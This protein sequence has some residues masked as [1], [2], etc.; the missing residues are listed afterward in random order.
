MAALDRLMSITRQWPAGGEDGNGSKPG[1]CRGRRLS[2][3][4]RMIGRRSALSIIGT[5]AIRVFVW[6]LCGEC[7]NSA[8]VLCSVMGR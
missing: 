7:R 3:C 5:A 2:P 6:G 1:E 8:A 4:S